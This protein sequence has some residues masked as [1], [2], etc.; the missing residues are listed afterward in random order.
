MEKQR[1]APPPASIGD[2]IN[3]AGCG[4]VSTVGG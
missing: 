2:K 3:T 4:V 1:L